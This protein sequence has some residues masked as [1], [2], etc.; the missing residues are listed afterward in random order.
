[1]AVNWVNKALAKRGL[2]YF[3]ATNSDERHQAVAKT[4]EV[5]LDLLT[6]KERER[7]S[8]LAIFPEDVEIPLSTLEKLWAKTGGFDEF[9]T[10]ELCS[11]LNRFS[12]LWN[13]DANQRRIRLH[14]VVRKFLI[15][16]QG[17][18][19]PSSH[20]QL[21]DAHRPGASGWAEM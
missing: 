9:D 15:Q 17:D 18:K 11:R 12:L 10:E 6:P 13:Y 19:L 16:Q 8:E 3:D 7:Y 2:T 21:L 5:S 20:A 1:D 14:D 4:I